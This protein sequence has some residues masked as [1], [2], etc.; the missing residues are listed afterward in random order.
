M[1]LIKKHSESVREV[2]SLVW[3]VYR[4]WLT[5]SYVQLG[6]LFIPTQFNSLSSFKTPQFKKA[7][8][9]NYYHQ[10]HVKFKV[11]GLC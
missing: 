5:V 8:I 2:P 10:L 11:I 9:E 6:Q 3:S 1:I 7:E 4:S